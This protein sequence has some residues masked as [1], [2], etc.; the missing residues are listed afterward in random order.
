MGERG[1]GKEK[2]ETGGAKDAKERKPT[3]KNHTGITSKV[4]LR[5]RLADKGDGGETKNDMP[6]AA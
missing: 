4:F 5:G 2:E 3:S 6:K 1:S